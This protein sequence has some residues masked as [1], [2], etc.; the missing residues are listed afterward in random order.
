MRAR[1]REREGGGG[2][3][4]GDE[5]ARDEEGPAP[6][7]SRC[8]EPFQCHV[9]PYTSGQIWAD[10][11]A[12]QVWL[13]CQCHLSILPGKSGFIHRS[14]ATSEQNCTSLVLAEPTTTTPLHAPHSSNK[15]RFGT[16]EGQGE[17]TKKH[18]IKTI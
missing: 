16:A 8:D 7:F 2:R 10:R 5:E 12:R 14:I 18:A 4:E 11:K 9:P 3:E 13:R 1:A 15:N 17:R 6:V